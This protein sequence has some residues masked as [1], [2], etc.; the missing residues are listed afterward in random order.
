MISTIHLVE[1]KP[2]QD[3]I[4]FSTQV[5]PNYLGQIATW[6]NA[7]IHRDIGT[8]ETLHKAQSDPLNAAVWEKTD[9]WQQ[10]FLEQPIHKQLT[11]D[12]T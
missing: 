11:V 8:L 6:Y 10:W 5:L 3:I 1:A 12:V 2:H 9:A 4:D 7:Q